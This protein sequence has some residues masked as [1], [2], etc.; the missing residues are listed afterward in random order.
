METVVRTEKDMADTLRA[1]AGAEESEAAARR[2]R[3][4]EEAIKGADEAAERGEQLRRLADR[5]ATHADVA[6]LF[7]LLYHAGTV[8]ADLA[9]TEEGIATELTSLA[10]QDGSDVADERRHLADEALA[11]AQRARDR[12]GALRRLAGTSAARAQPPVG[13]PAGSGGT[14]RCQSG[15]AGGGR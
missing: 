3:L 11:G 14:A 2:L 5:W 8:L 1:I 10:G 7:Q 9:S 13:G 4:A 12:A 6:A 15:E